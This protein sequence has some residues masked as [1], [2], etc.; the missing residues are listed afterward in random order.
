MWYYFCFTSAP[1]ERFPLK[2]PT[3]II[4]LQ[5]PTVI[6]HHSC[7]PP[8]LIAKFHLFQ[9]L[10]KSFTLFFNDISQVTRKLF[11]VRILEVKFN[12]HRKSDFPKFSAQIPYN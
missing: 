4:S 7:I 9:I 2:F 11:Q 3:W 12:A 10:M 5:Q 8:S 6:S 1:I